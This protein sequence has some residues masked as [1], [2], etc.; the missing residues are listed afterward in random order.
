MNQASITKIVSD[1][2]F[3]GDKTEASLVETHISWVILTKEWAFKIKKPVNFGFLDFTTPEARQFYCEEEL[4][5]NRRLSPDIYLRVLPVGEGGIGD[6]KTPAV[7]HALQ[8][9]RID[10]TREMDKLLE[11]NAV[12]ETDMRQLA[13]ILAPFH[14]SNRLFDLPPYDPAEDIRDFADLFR[15]EKELAS[16]SGDAPALLEQWSRWLPAFFKQ[17]LERIKERTRGGYWIEG[18]GDL[19]S[20]NIFLPDK[21]LPIIF[22][23]IEFNAHFRRMEVLNELA[24]LCMDLE[25][26]GQKKLADVFLDEYAKHWVCF[27]RPEDQL[28]FTYYKAYRANIRLKVTLLQWQQH[29]EAPL[30]VMANTYWKLLRSYCTE[31]T[32]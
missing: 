21:E 23:C 9:R 26:Y 25:F 16:L 6:T 20:R 11:I 32:R 18:H 14:L 2:L 19:H 28:L 12:G 30:L 17:H 24:F 5:L 29:Q 4:R 27:E 15:L 3:P 22:D 8:M 10:N 13:Q 1:R 7:D 31:L